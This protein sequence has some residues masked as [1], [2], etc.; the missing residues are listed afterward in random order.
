MEQIQS[1]PH[2]QVFSCAEEAFIDLKDMLN[3]HKGL[4]SE[5][6]WSRGEQILFN[7]ENLW[8][9]KSYTAFVFTKTKAFRSVYRLENYLTIFTRSYSVTKM[10]DLER[11][12][13]SLR[14]C[15]TCMSA[16]EI[17]LRSWIPPPRLIFWKKNENV[18]LQNC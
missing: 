10:H 2:D 15:E 17:T 18:V 5:N 9:L 13:F 3:I 7:E 16:R 14:V 11:S 6:T 1:F 4:F 8:K 12:E